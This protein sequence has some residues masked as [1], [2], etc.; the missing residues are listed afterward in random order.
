MNTNLVTFA[1]FYIGYLLFNVGGWVYFGYLLY[2]A[3]FL[4][5]DTCNSYTKDFTDVAKIFLGVA[6]ATTSLNIVGMTM[7]AVNSTE[8]DI[9][10][11]RSLSMDHLL[12]MFIATFLFLSV[13]GIFALSV[14]GVTSGM[15]NIQ[16][17]D[18]NAEFALKLLVYGMSWIAFVE[19]VVVLGLILSFLY[20]IIKYAKVC[21]PCFDI[22]KKYRERR[23]VCSGDGTGSCDATMVS[24]PSVKRYTTCHVTIPMPVA[25]E[26]EDMKLLCSICYDASLTLLLEPCNH[27]CMCDVCYNSLVKKECPVC[28]TE[29]SATKKVYFATPGR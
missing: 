5:A 24:D 15:S 7:D 27:I 4:K 6:M 10:N 2:Y 13:S 14:F 3:S 29:I 25:S 28:K 21:E 1:R 17:S 12:C 26:K 19:M 18:A 23:V 9:D 16:C 20:D 11:G 8:R 22:C